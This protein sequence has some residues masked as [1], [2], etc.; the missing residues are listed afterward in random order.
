MQLILNVKNYKIKIQVLD[1]DSSNTHIN[2]GRIFL[3]ATIKKLAIF[4]IK[5]K[6]FNYRLFN[7]V[8]RQTID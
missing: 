8:N 3:R 4:K 2:Y 5:F 6:E 1:C 7:I